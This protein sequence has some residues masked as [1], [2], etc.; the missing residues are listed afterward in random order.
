VVY[1]PGL[2]DR[3]DA[4]KAAPWNGTVYRH[5]FGR[6]KPD[7]ENT[8]GAR[9]NP[10]DTSAIYVCL[11]HDGAVAEGDHVIAMQP[12]RPK[13]D[14]TVYE[15]KVTLTNVLDLSDRAVLSAL[16]I[17]DAEL[18]DPAMTA[19]RNVGGAVAWLGHDGLLVP[20]ARSR[21]TNLIIYASNQQP[22]AVFDVINKHP[23]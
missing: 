16:G 12:I 8:R 22:D 15:V 1:S 9:W 6:H 21:A 18:D 19:C 17:G 14:R 10:P 3:L 23:V 20:S 5:M 7:Q 2:L 4:A 13:A 11:N